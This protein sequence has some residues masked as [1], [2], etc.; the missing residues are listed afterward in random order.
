MSKD[1]TFIPEPPEDQAVRE[2][3]IIAVEYTDKLNSNDDY[4]KSYASKLL[5]RQLGDDAE[6]ESVKVKKPGRVSRRISRALN[7]VP[8]AKLHIK[9][10]F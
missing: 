5:K 6:V 3:Y 9:T 7:R 1:D 4:L 2:I 8:Q 10:K